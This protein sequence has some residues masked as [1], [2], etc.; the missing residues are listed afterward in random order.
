MWL[1]EARTS[2][3]QF[4]MELEDLFCF[5]FFFQNEL[6]VINCMALMESRHGIRYA[7][8]VFL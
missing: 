3:L 8:I 7:V 5:V 6:L 4:K 1:P 2:S